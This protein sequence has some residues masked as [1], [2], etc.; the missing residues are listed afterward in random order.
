MLN[1]TLASL[2]EE[3][4]DYTRGTGISTPM[5]VLSEIML[6]YAMEN[7]IGLVLD[8]NF[9][10]YIQMARNLENPYHLYD[11]S[12]LEEFLNAVDEALEKE[13]HGKVSD[14]ITLL[15]FMY[16]E[17]ENARFSEILG[18]KAFRSTYEAFVKE[19]FKSSENISSLLY[20]LSYQAR[21]DWRDSRSYT[22][23]ILLAK[24][25]KLDDTALVRE[26]LDN[27]E[28]MLSA[29]AITTG[30]RVLT[31]RNNLVTRLL[32]PLSRKNGRIEE[33]EMNSLL[34]TDELPE[35]LEKAFTES[36]RIAY[37]APSSLL[38]SSSKES[39]ETREALI[40]SGRIE[41]VI[42]LPP[43]TAA[44]NE[45]VTV[46]MLGEKTND[47]VC[48]ADLNSRSRDRSY[49]KDNQLTENA[50]DAVALLLSE[51]KE[52]E[53]ITRIVSYD[54]VKERKILVP[55]NYL[56][57]KVEERKDTKELEKRIEELYG[58]LGALIAL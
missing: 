58:K 22:L 14:M 42:V 31:D 52:T 49:V 24:A 12:E 54:E 6:R 40:E 36:R 21:K 41:G 56:E 29:I 32:S 37:L 7:R 15:P 30:G 34:I 8:R 33:G 9:E 38:L 2:Y 13:G 18:T 35:D 17:K 11:R 51:R 1:E 16:E 57:G 44:S 3:L 45:N 25:L 46:L 23:G 39:L 26:Q 27:S 4:R 48:F 55:M 53:G 43:L 19:D 28:L 47:D 10:L 20:T 50:M 5:L